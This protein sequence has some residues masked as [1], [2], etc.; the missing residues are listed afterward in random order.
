M[1]IIASAPSETWRSTDRL[2][3]PMA[4]APVS[5]ARKTV[6]PCGG[7]WRRGR[8]WGKTG[9]DGPSPLFAAI[10]IARSPTTAVRG[11]KHR[12]MVCRPC[13]QPKA[14]PDG[15]PPL[16]AATSIARLGCENTARRVTGAL[17]PRAADEWV[18]SAQ[19]LWVRSAG[20]GLE[21]PALRL[22]KSLEMRRFERIWEKTA[23]PGPE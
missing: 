7:S 6:S 1:G 10:S 17:C 9:P 12:P 3:W 2:A 4:V 16:N 13:M 18:L 5:G 23:R 11:E 19:K 21:F 15:P 8:I 14:L 20:L 22:A